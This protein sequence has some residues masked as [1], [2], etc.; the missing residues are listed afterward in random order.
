MDETSKKILT[1]IGMT[2]ENENQLNEILIP[3]ETFINDTIYN[4]VKEHISEL[5]TIFSSSSLTS[6]QKQ[7]GKSQRWPLLNLIRQILNVYG[8]HMKPIRKSAGYTADGVKKFTRFFLIQKKNVKSDNVSST[9]TDDVDNLEEDE[10]E[11]LMEC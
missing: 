11:S 9:N 6:L 4:S 5:K 3:R 10:V 1:K 7:A 8:F 2:F